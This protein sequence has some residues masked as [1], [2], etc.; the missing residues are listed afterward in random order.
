M[1][2]PIWTDSAMTHLKGKIKETPEDDRLYSTLGKCYALIGDQKDAIASGNKAVEMK[3][4]KQDFNIGVRREQ[5]LMEIFIL[6]D[7]Y[8]LA[9]EKVE[10]LLSKPSWLNI[11]DL[12]IDPIFDK[13]HE[14]PRFKNIIN[15]A[16]E[17][18]KI[19][20]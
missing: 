15:P 11:G 17:K 16:Q 9:L 4:I 10:D 3:P 7:N 8:D 2:S 14:L 13:L 20:Q 19:E 1:F 5:D 18:I 12:K 6:T